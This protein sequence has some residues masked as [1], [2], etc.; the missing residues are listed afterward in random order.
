MRRNIHVQQ[1]EGDSN[2][3]GSLSVV[4][5]TGAVITLG[6]QIRNEMLITFVQRVEI[7]LSYRHFVRSFVL[8]YVGE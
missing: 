6:R 7:K 8:S 1:V 2:K 5:V 3:Q 4:P